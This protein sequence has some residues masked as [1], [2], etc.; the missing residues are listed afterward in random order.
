MF[1]SPPIKVKLSREPFQLLHCYGAA[2]SAAPSVTDLDWRDRRM[3]MP[4]ISA[5]KPVF[6]P[7]ALAAFAYFTP[8]LRRY[9]GAGGLSLRSL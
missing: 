8:F 2:G 6:Q 1:G 4:E 5:G 9:S 7:V 3:Y